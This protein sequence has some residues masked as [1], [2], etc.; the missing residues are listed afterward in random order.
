MRRLSLPIERIKKH[1]SVVVV[2]SGYGGAIAASRMARAGQAVC[3]LERGKELQPGEYP[4]NLAQATREFQSDSPIGHEGAHTGLYDF[5]IN[6]D[7]NVMLGCGLGGTSLVNA[8]VGLRAEPRVFEDP[9]WP[10]GFRT[11]A[12][13]VEQ[14]YARAERMLHPRPVPDSFA[15]LPKMEALHTSATAMQ[16]PWYRTPLYVTFDEPEGGVN[17]FGVTQHTC[18]GCGDCVSG[19]NFHAKNTTLMN[20][21]P[22]AVNF[23]AE[24][25]TAVAVRYLE[26]NG[27]GWR[28]HFQTLAD[29]RQRFDAPDLFVT[30]DVVILGAGALGSTEILLRSAANGLPMSPTVGEHFTGNGDVLGYGYNTDTEINTIGFGAHDPAGR[31]VVGPCITSVI[32]LRNQPDL[33]SGMVIEEGSVP[34]PMAELMPLILD[35]AKALDH[36]RPT[37]IPEAVAQKKRQLESLIEGPYHGAVHNTQIYLVMTHDGTAGRMFLKDDRLRI[38]WPG[39]GSEPIFAK[40]N[41]NL[42]RATEPLGGVY[43]SNPEW[44]ALQKKPLVS[45]HP[46]G[47]CIMAEGA[48]Q[49]VVNHKGQVFSGAA[50]SAVYENLYVDD[51]A[52]LPRSL[53]VN[54]SLTI[55]AVAERTCAL[56]AKDRG[57]TIDYSLPSRPAPAVPAPTVGVQFTETMKGFWSPGAATYEAGESA[58]K[59]ADNGF[60]FTLTVRGD[61]VDRMVSEPGHDGTMVGTVVAHALSSKPLMVSNGVFNLFVINP[62]EEE[63]RNMR[64]RMTMV[65]E[66]GRTWYLE[67]FKTIHDRPAWDVWHDTTTLFIT[68]YE[69]TDA[70]RPALGKGI[71]HIEPLDFARQLTTFQVTNAAT[72]TQRVDALARFGTFFAKS[73]FDTYGGLA[74][75]PTAFD[76][77]APPRVKRPLRVG[78]PVIYPVQTEDGV[79]LRL[80]RYE[81]GSKGPVVL[82]HGLG[83]SSGIF[84]L[85]TVDTNLLEY[86]Y[87]HGYDVWLLDFRNSIALPASAAQSSGDDVARYD[88][89]AAVAKVR[90]ITTAKDVQMVVHCWGSTTFF[91]AM[92]AGLEGVRSVV[93]SQIATQVVA[94]TVGRIKT[95]LHLPS[96]LNAIGLD[97]LTAFASKKEDLINR[98]YD[99][100]LRLYPTALKEWCQNLT[101]HRI[102]FMYAPL[103]NHAQLNELTHSTLHE[104]FGVA[105]MKCFLHLQRLTNTGHLVDF[106]GTDVYMPHLDRLAIPITFIHGADNACFLPESTAR[107]VDELSRRNGKNLYERHVI[108]GYG[109]ID[110]IF[111]KN[112]VTDVYPFILDALDAGNPARAKA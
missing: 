77:S 21:L 106:D 5:R 3:L 57:W 53:G 74:A 97:A 65:S 90:A 54:P 64:Y 109:H 52:V 8:N 88:Y 48:E 30:A 16:A 59:A 71:L 81:G 44:H 87:A 60:M 9:G 89:P 11:D 85:D 40:A 27:K 31:E 68:V 75:R 79:S 29:G 35:A 101:C 45:V 13:L 73:I 91:M 26:R 96:F 69:G 15:A 61:D 92:L 55:S 43:L 14:S 110:C 111:G 10:E 58:G 94:S 20:Y 103:Y 98:V 93:S 51:G 102:T 2:G 38:S 70:S 84:S 19:C 83:V 82:C 33:N 99:A 4:T 46:L 25:F 78:A 100:G 32:D 56:I 47:G 34:G 22:D 67:G 86:L 7:I 76:T 105:N 36:T 17:E 28:V 42:K 41:D 66:E 49:G 104:T 18:I 37:S 80:T 108:P 1:Y 6:D 63:T 23:G 112:A 95:G 39:V 24:I 12:A 72:A 107:T 50:G 62:N